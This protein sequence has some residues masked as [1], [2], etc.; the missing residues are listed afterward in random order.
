MASSTAPTA[1]AA[2]NA[3]AVSPATTPS[4]QVLTASRRTGLRSMSTRAT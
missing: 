3:A 4:T 1:N 2:P